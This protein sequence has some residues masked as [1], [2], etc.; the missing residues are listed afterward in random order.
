VK[1]DAADRIGRVDHC[2]ARKR[3]GPRQLQRLVRGLAAYREDDD[4]AEPSGVSE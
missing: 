4:L 1:N 3:A 2:L